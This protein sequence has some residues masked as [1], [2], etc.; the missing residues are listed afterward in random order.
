MILAS[1]NA[2]RLLEQQG[3]MVLVVSEESPATFARSVEEAGDR[4][5]CYVN[6]YWLA[7]HLYAAAVCGI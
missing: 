7:P 3:P 4:L 6:C 2:E 5:N 1:Q